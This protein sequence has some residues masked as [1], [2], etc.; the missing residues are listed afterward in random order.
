MPHTETGLLFWKE[1]LR[2]SQIEGGLGPFVDSSY[3]A[4]TMLAMD[5]LMT[6]SLGHHGRPVSGGNVLYRRAF[7]TEKE[8]SALDM[9]DAMRHLSWPRDTAL[10]P[11]D[12]TALDRH[13]RRASWLIAGLLILN[14]GIGSDPRYFR[15]F[16]PLF[17]TATLV[18]IGAV[19]ARW[20]SGRFGALVCWRRRR[21]SNGRPVS[22]P[23]KPG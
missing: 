12:R 7:D 17:R 3:P 4:E 8:K 19:P 21:I 9:V 5:A 11:E 14:D 10:T 13:G 6:A 16:G 22:K 18:P 23:M 20:P 2:H 1:R 15:R